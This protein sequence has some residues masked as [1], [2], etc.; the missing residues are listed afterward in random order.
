MSVKYT[1]R[2]AL[3]DNRK[4]IDGKQVINNRRLTLMDILEKIAPDVIEVA[5]TMTVVIAGVIAGVTVQIVQAVQEVVTVQIIIDH[6][7]A[8][9]T[10]VLSGRRTTQ[11]R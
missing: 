9:K 3:I 11:N 1:A 4:R 8:T 10:E 5:T 7:T 2:G 6:K